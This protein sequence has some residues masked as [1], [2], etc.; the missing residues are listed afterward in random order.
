M[1]ILGSS[2]PVLP[3]ALLFLVA[4]F[5]LSSVSELQDLL[6]FS[7]SARLLH[8]SAALHCSAGDAPGDRGRPPRSRNASAGAASCPR[9]F[10]RIREHLA[11][12]RST[13]I[14]RRSLDR[15]QR[16]GSM[17]VA[18][19]GGRMYVR[20]Y[21]DCPQSRSV[22]SLWGLLL[23][24]E[25]FGDRVP[26]VEFVL[27]CK[28]R[29]IV[30]RDGSYGGVPSP[31]LSYCSHRHSLDIPFPDYSFWGW[32]EVNI[33][34][35]EQESQEIFQG[36]QDV[37]W[38]K[39]QP[40]AFWK[41]NLRMGKLR[42]LLARCNSTEF[43]TL[44]FDQNWI[45]EAN[46]GYANSKLCK[47]CNQRYNIYAEGAAWSASLKYK[48]ACGSTLLYLDSEYDEFFTKGL[49]PNIHFMPI[50]S[51]EEEMCQ[52]LRDAVNW[53]NSHAHEAQNI[54]RS[55][56]AFMREQVNIDQVYNYMFHLLSEYSRLQ[57]F[58]P[59]IPRG[60]RFFCRRAL[61]YI[62]ELYGK[63]NY[64]GAHKRVEDSEP[65]TMLFNITS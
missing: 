63:Q 53:G 38:N 49:L 14:T 12:W 36:S 57:R 20:A 40:L 54:G 31:V 59:E 2:S 17:R 28:D 43:G 11:P 44:V 16:L 23:M 42:N 8:K 56:Q 48:M 55:G 22:F 19:L 5:L 13:G 10:A 61:Q 60:G 47:Q 27:N 51:K 32:P 29:P 30:P 4:I 52:S 35:W 50:S 25:R 24:L 34:P 41:G 64:I 46:V 7:R 65:C 33:R 9:Y 15:R 62:A 37:E 39:R 3:L 1:K 26:D 18:I 21:G 58:T 6:F 45:A